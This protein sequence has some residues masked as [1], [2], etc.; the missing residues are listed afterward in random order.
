MLT[1]SIDLLP[2]STNASL[3]SGRG[4]GRLVST[5]EARHFK[6]VAL[7][8]TALGLQQSIESDQNVL[9]EILSYT[10]RELKATITYQSD[11]WY[12]ASNSI[13]KKDV[14]NLAK[15]FLDST[16]EA[17]R[18]YNPSLD[19]SQIFSVL[20]QKSYLPSCADKTVLTLEIL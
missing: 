4:G 1:L 16:F 5:P 6:E 9:T 12:T 15:G 11:I 10:G 3:M 19:D 20:L 8:S 7:L 18:V 2:L 17:L 14:D 13:R